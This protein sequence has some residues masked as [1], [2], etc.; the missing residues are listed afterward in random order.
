MMRRRLGAL[1]AVVALA[2]A[3]SAAPEPVAPEA[4]E[5]F[6]SYVGAD[7]VA[8]T[9][10]LR[11]FSAET[12]IA[13]YYVGTSGFAEEFAGRIDRDDLPDV[14]LL[15]QPGFLPDLVAAGAVAPLPGDVVERLRG[16][17]Q[18]ESGIGVVDGEVV[19]VWFRGLVKSLV[20]YH[21]PTFTERGWEVPTTTAEL[22]ALVARA[23]DAGIVPWCLTAGAF[24]STGWVLSDWFE[25]LL[26]RE[27]TEAYDAVVA[28]DSFDQPAVVAALTALRDLVRTP[29]SVAGGPRRALSELVEDAQAPMF[30]D[31]PGCLLHRQSAVNETWLPAGVRVGVD[32]DVF[33]LPGPTAAAPLLVGGELAVALSDAREVASLMRWLADPAALAPFEGTGG[34]LSPLG[35]L[36]AGGDD[37]ERRQL[38]L[39]A[40]AGVVRFDAS[41]LLPPELGT[42]LLWQALVDLAGGRASV[43]QVVDRLEAARLD[44][45]AERP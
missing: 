25:E 42:T 18:L 9:E 37:L 6:G 44:W 35:D 41:D 19:G 15:P 2:G 43:A 36:G 10:S 33:A 8:F 20:W 39:L 34:F 32:T 3:C 24:A 4:I 45:L 30:G 1:V 13:A 12:G 40:E 31:P 14:V 26:L 23:S 21:L 29:G 5:V 27:S 38:D 28:L 16:G 22:D 17:T 11:A 7:A